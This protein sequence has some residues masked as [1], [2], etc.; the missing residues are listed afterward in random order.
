MTLTI[1]ASLFPEIEA[2]HSKVIQYASYYEVIT[3]RKHCGNVGWFS[4]IF[5]CFVC[6]E[7]G[8]CFKSSTLGQK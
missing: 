2:L 1:P 4:L 6:L 5:Y 8:D 7:R 3:S